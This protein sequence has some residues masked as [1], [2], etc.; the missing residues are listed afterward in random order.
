MF[1][2]E[3]RRRRDAETINRALDAVSAGA[4]HAEAAA[5]VG[6]PLGT[7]RTWLRRPSIWAD[8]SGKRCVLVTSSWNA[9]PCLFPQ[10]G[11]GRK[12]E[13][14]I[15]LASWQQEIVEAKGEAFLRGTIHSDGCRTV[16]RFT[17]RLPS[18]RVGE[19]A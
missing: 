17:T 14:R 7:L 15:V 2:W 6:V 11:P 10:H 3:N 19:Y 18:G 13:R 4:P 16:N 5:V 8:R 12:H 1:P 9:W